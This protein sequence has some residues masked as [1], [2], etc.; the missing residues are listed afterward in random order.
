LHQ[1]AKAGE[2]ITK[3]TLNNKAALAKSIA[4]KITGLV[5]K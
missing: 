4:G 3:G 5:K 1:N 2:F